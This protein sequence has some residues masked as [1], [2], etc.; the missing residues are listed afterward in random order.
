MCETQKIKFS[1]FFPTF[2]FYI[3]EIRELLPIDLDVNIKIKVYHIT[4][5]YQKYKN[6]VVEVTLKEIK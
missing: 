1:K 4:Y 5:Y 6:Y 3:F 2:N